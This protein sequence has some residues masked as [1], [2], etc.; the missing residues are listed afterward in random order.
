MRNDAYGL[1]WDEK[2]R[3]KKF[4][5]GQNHQGTLYSRS[6]YVTFVKPLK[7]LIHNMHISSWIHKSANVYVY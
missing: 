5:F 4:T 6:N 1:S 7:I 2:Q 3:M